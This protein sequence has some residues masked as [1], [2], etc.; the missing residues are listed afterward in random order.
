M[1]TKE[2]QT[3]L[4]AL[5]LYMGPIDGINGE[6]TK[7]AVAAFQT[8]VGIGVDGKA[9]PMTQA[10]LMEAKPIAPMPARDVDP[11]DAL[12]ASAKPIW[13]RQKDVEKF[14]G[15]VGQNQV[16]L[17]LPFPMRIAWD[18]STTVTR[19]S[20]HEK[21]HDSAKRAFTAIGQAYG[22]TERSN[23]GL[24][25]FGGCLNVRKMRGGNRMSMHSWGIAIDFDPDRNALKTPF[26]KARLGQPD[27]ARF[28]GI[29]ENEGWVSL[30]RTSNFDAMHVQAARL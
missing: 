28:W 20:I 27:C 21:V 30:G 15:P 25:I 23:L 17:Q 11:P 10:R 29:W 1:D 9:G 16:M 8:A 13:P 22:A 12:Q 26:A 14:Y 19:F 3:R 5:G 6:G 4:T 18:L 24:D 2:I 7:T